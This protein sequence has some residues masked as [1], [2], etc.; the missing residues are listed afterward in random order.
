RNH[1]LWDQDPETMPIYGSIASQ[2]N[3]PGTNALYKGLM[4]TIV[5]KTG[6]DLKSSFIATDEQSEK[7]YIIP[8]A[9]TRYLSEIAE[10][11]RSYNQK[12]ID[13]AEVAQKLY[14]IHKTI[15]TIQSS[16]IED[17]DRLI[18]ELQE[19][20]HNVSLDLD[21]KNLETLKTWESKKSNYQ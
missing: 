4:D 18:K 2:F 1:N 13:Q 3:D 12:A 16:N 9:R 11:N 19:V 10:N 20:Y 7:I 14:G 6:A 5:A 15:D 17:K 8:P 21:P